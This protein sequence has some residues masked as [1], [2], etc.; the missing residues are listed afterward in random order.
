VL[1]LWK[2]RGKTKGFLLIRTL[3]KIL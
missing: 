1:P 2:K 3:L